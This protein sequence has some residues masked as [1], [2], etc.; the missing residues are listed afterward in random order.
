[1]NRQEWLK[2]KRKLAEIRYDEIF[3][4]DYDEKWGKINDIH[5]TN[6]AYF[7]NLLPQGVIVLDAACGTGKYR[8]IIND[9]G[10]H[11]LGID[12]S[13][14]M[15]NKAVSKYKNIETNKLG[16]QEIN[17][18]DEFYG[19][20]CIDAMEN[21]FPEEWLLVLENFYNALKK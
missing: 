12:Q 9:T 18:N 13:Q 2:E 6:L 4:I 8:Q 19:V 20:V 11:V 14:Q 5:K 15:L 3:S 16:L 17:Y 7:L 1:M 21:V 10:Y